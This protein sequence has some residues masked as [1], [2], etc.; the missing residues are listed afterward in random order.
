LPPMKGTFRPFTV[1][2]KEGFPD[3]PINAVQGDEFSRYKVAA[4]VDTMHARKPTM[5][6]ARRVRIV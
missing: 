2:H 3:M 5:R 1:G 6:R 4:R